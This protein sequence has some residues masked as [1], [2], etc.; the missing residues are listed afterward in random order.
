MSRPATDSDGDGIPDD[1]D[2]CPRTPNPGQ[3]DADGDGVGDACD[4]C[5][6]HANRG[7]EDEDHDGIGDVCDNRAPV[8]QAT[9]STALL[10]PPNHQL[11][12]ISVNGVTDPD[13]D[14]VLLTITSI[15]QDEPTNTD[16]DGNHMPDAMGVG[17]SMAMIR[18]ER[19]GT[20][21]VPGDGRVYHIAFRASDGKGGECTGV[22]KVGVPHDQGPRRFP[23]DG[24]PLYDS[25]A[26]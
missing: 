2:N 6:T 21:K 10:W 26:P 3:E 7:Q 13:G 8:C 19:A 1:L 5:L 23:V 15:R 9:P 24:G 14:A 22:V 25:T 11:E 16:G 12:A 17:T 18:A 4:N 20:P